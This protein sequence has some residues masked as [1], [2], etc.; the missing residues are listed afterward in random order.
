[1][2]HDGFDENYFVR[3]QPGSPRGNLVEAAT[4]WSVRGMK[5]ILGILII[6]VW[7]IIAQS[8]LH[9][10]L[11]PIFRLLA[12]AF[13]LPHRRFYTPATDYASVE[14]EEGL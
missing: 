1:M 14:P 13:M 6:F 2:F 9:V 4:W 7:R 12:H 11:P 5:M 8:I 10:V 3:I